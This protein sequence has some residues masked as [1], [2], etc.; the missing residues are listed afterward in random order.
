MPS[1]SASAPL[2]GIA[3]KSF[4]GVT[5]AP[6][7][8]P[9]GHARRPAPRGVGET[10]GARARLLGLADQRNA[11]GEV[12]LV[13]RLRALPRD[14]SLAV[15]GAADPRRALHLLDR[16]ALARQHRLI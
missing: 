2:P 14:R 12:G 5:A 6:R 9:R 10:R 13:A 11:R 8:P 16:L 7:A 3:L 4:G 1:T 15:D